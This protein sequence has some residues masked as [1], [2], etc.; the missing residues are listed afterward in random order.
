[1]PFSSPSR[2]FERLVTAWPDVAAQCLDARIRR[3]VTEDSSKKGRHVGQDSQITYDLSPFFKG[4]QWKYDRESAPLETMLDNDLWSMLNHPVTQVFISFKWKHLRRFFIITLAFDILMAFFF[5][6]FCVGPK[7]G[8]VGEHGV[9]WINVAMITV[10]ISVQLLKCFIAGRRRSQRSKTDK[11]TVSWKPLVLTVTNFSTFTKVLFTVT[12]V[13]ALAIKDDLL[14]QQF[15]CWGGFLAWINVIATLRKEPSTGI[16]IY[17]F[18]EVLL[19]T[20]MFLL[21][22]MCLFLAFTVACFALLQSVS[23]SFGDLG[24]AFQSTL[25]LSFSYWTVFNLSI[26]EQGNLH[27]LL[28][29]VLFFLCSIT[30]ISCIIGLAIAT[31][32]KIVCYKKDFQTA[33]KVSNIIE[34]EQF[35]F[36]LAKTTKLWHL[37]SCSNMAVN[38]MTWL[39]DEEDSIVLL[40]PDKPLLSG[41]RQLRSAFRKRNSDRQRYPLWRK[42]TID[43]DEAVD[44]V[45]L[46]VH[47]DQALVNRSNSILEEAE[48]VNNCGQDQDADYSSLYWN[49]GMSQSTD[50]NGGYEIIEN[51]DR[52]DYSNEDQSSRIKDS[53]LRELRRDMTR[54]LRLNNP[55]AENGGKSVNVRPGLALGVITLQAGSKGPKLSLQ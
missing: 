41:W 33:Q 14:R 48:V 53:L 9:L 52:Q 18:R 47:V 51:N 46:G 50:D 38:S 37:M 39:R 43:G 21:S 13:V 27:L 5:T 25:A 7:D 22:I 54:L 17:I 8:G 49:A 34:I 1:M 23:S 11:R 30:V 42:K 24:T 26:D 55:R 6:V 12:A 28:V 44:A 29:V 40:F 35:L 3:K 16:N 32:S 15:S 36:P 20:V 10:F 31:I 2:V 45:N 19:R 4:C